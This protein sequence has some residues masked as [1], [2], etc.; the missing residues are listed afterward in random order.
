VAG[1]SARR[2]RSRNDHIATPLTGTPS[3]TRACPGGLTDS[4]PLVLQSDRQAGSVKWR[5]IL[6]PPKPAGP[7]GLT[8]SAPLSWSGRHQPRLAHNPLDH[9]GR[10]GWREKGNDRRSATSL[11]FC[12]SLASEYPKR[13]KEDPISRNCRLTLCRVSSDSTVLNQHAHGPQNRVC[14]GHPADRD[15]G[16][17]VL[18]Q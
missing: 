2:P 8:D 7:G 15:R 13:M 16:S 9:R 11:G 5:K 6:P 14:H 17:I 3:A 18:S 10:P 1:N 4:A 12:S